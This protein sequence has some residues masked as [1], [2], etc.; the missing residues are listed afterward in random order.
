MAI[1][2]LQLRRLQVPKYAQ[3]GQPAQE[4]WVN[5][6]TES[7]CGCWAD[8]ISKCR[9]IDV[10]LS[11]DKRKSEDC[12]LS[13]TTLNP[14]LGVVDFKDGGDG[15]VIADIPGLIEGASQGVGLGYE[16]L[17]HI[18]R[19]KMMIHVVDAASSEGRD[20]IEDIYKINAEP[21]NYNRRDR[22]AS[23]GDRGK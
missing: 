23:S 13:F 19:T 14:N 16:F 17:R 12:K 18:E 9:K 1:S 10:P 11:C 6:G 4:L 15:F 5:S 7:D 2:I 21:G 8:R 22:K 20:P 3:P